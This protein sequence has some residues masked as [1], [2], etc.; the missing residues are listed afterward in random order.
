VTFAPLKSLAIYP[1]IRA[2]TRIADKVQTV[3]IIHFSQTTGE[4]FGLGVSFSFALFSIYFKPR[5]ICAPIFHIL[6]KYHHFS[7]LYVLQW[8]CILCCSILLS[9]ISTAK[10]PQAGESSF[11]LEALRDAGAL[12]AVVKSQVSRTVKVA[13][14]SHVYI[15][16]RAGVLLILLDK[17]RHT[18]TR[19]QN[20]W[21]ICVHAW[22]QAKTNTTTKT[23]FFLQHCFL[24][25][26]LL[27]HRFH[28]LSH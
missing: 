14:M 12:P 19:A 23:N 9:Y 26:L 11:T 2:A 10:N 1:A 25:N 22:A 3:A 5:I 6:T 28:A 24:P 18:N 7:I 15:Q 21:T 16:E 13:Q 8:I 27:Y 17:C 20:T 4:G